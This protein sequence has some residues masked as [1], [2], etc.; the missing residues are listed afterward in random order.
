MLFDSS[1]THRKFE[2]VSFKLHRNTKDQPY[3]P[4]KKVYTSFFFFTYANHKEKMYV[5]HL[6]QKRFL[7]NED[8]KPQTDG[9]AS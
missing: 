3:Q 4:S 9:W 2:I 1:V 5:L 6:M 7:G 8:V